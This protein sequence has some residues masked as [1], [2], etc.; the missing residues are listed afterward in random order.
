MKGLMLLFFPIYIALMGTDSILKPRRAP[1]I[2]ISD[3]VSY[4]L[5]ERETFFKTSFFINLKPHCESGIFCFVISEISQDIN[6]FMIWRSRGIFL[7]FCIL[8]PIII[9]LSEY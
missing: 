5:V 2:N 3:S 1:L 7:I 9:P 8:F 6:L 4:F